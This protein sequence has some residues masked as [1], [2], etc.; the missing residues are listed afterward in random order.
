VRRRRRRT[1]G[2]MERWRKDHLE[3]SRMHAHWRAGQKTNPASGAM[4][5]VDV[6]DSRFARIDLLRSPVQTNLQRGC[7]AGRSGDAR[8]SDGVETEDHEPGAGPEKP[9]PPL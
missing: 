2:E 6:A 5:S 3:L 7:G 9:R 1:V 4:R 8:R